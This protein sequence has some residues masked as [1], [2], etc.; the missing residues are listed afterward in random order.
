LK[1]RCGVPIEIRAEV[2]SYDEAEWKG[3]VRQGEERYARK[4][5][6][7][8]AQVIEAVGTMCQK[9]DGDPNI[10]GAAIAKDMKT[11]ACVVKNPVP[12]SNE[13]GPDEF[14]KKHLSYAHGVL[15]AQVHPT[16]ANVDRDV[17]IIV[18][19][20]LLK[21]PLAPKGFLADPRTSRDNGDPCT[22]ASECSSLVCQAGVCQGCGPKAACGAGYFCDR[23][24]CWN[25]AAIE[26]QHAS[27]QAC[28]KRGLKVSGD[29][30]NGNADCCS[31]RC[32]GSPRTFFSCE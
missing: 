7:V 2:S 20:G 10:W 24:K 21:H 1:K 11:V 28:K 30:C 9:A 3:A 26:R 13:E 23:R 15:T 17:W 22:A 25:K 32:T 6:D 27:D 29:R 14:T 18:A 5:L 8:C 12:R 4:P 16:L 31:G 19:R